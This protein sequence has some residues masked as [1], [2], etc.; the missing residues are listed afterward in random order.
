MAAAAG[1]TGRKRHASEAGK[2]ARFFVCR[3]LTGRKAND[4]IRLTNE[5]GAAAGGSEVYPRYLSMQ[6]VTRSASVDMSS[7][8]VGHRKAGDQTTDFRLVR[9]FVGSLTSKSEERET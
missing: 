4:Y 2:T 8:M 9:I 7:R 3:V 1:K 5:G 6:A